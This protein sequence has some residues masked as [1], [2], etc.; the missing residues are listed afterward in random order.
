MKTNRTTQLF[1]KVPSGMIIISGLKRPPSLR[2]EG[3]ISFLLHKN[4]WVG[5]IPRAVSTPLP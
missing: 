5:E 2:G 3:S 1:Y 4:Q